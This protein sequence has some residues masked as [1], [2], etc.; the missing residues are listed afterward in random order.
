[1]LEKQPLSRRRLLSILGAGTGLLAA[2]LAA[3]A[4]TGE[5]CGAATPQQILGPFFPSRKREDEDV[6]LT[7]IHGRTERAEGE[8]VQVSGQILD[9]NCQPV[10]GALVEIW[11][12]NCHG[13]YDHE[14]DANNPR[15]L[16]P[17]FQGWAR[18]TTG[19][20]GR[21]AI[22]TIKPGSYPADDSG[23][24]RPPHIHFKVSRR[25]YQELVTQMY[26]EGEPL[27]EP[28]HLRR[29]LSAADQAR[30]TV[31]FADAPQ[32][33]PGARAGQF[34]ITLRKA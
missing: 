8:L 2:P 32:V 1:M 3:P 10:E 19:P 7:M 24:I 11:Q 21:F 28:D 30:V 14:R 15:P 4:A 9:D 18:F 33:G 20:D 6:D 16:D 34:D 12:A 31:A 13:R 23:W 27:N 26:F 25:G 22:K 29:A 17:N 5:T